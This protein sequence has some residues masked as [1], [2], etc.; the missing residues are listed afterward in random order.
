MRKCVQKRSTILKWDLV[1]Q[2][3]QP[4]VCRKKTDTNLQAQLCSGGYL[5]HNSVNLT[6]LQFLFLILLL[7]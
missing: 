7:S 4:L 1:I 6:R 3:I 5:F 2:E